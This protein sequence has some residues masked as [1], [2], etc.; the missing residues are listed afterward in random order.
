[1]KVNVLRIARGQIV[2]PVTEIEV[3]DDTTYAEIMVVAKIEYN[4]RTMSLSF[5]NPY[6]F[7]FSGEL[8][9]AIFLPSDGV[10]LG[11]FDKDLFLPVRIPA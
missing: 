2:E 4:P 8:P 3:D 5:T 7:S 1:M 10:T 9:D 11:V 6:G